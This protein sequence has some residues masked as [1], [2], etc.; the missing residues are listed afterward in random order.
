MENKFSFAAVGMFV[1]GFGIVLLSLIVWLTVGTEKVTYLPYKV[2]T[3][4]S[5]SGLSV[6][7]I[8][9]YKGVN[10]GVVKK[11]QLNDI[12][13][14]YV[15]ISLDIIKG[16]PVKVDTEAVLTSRGITGLVT[17]SLRDGTESSPLMLPTETDPVPEIKNGPSLAK[18]L[19]TAFNEITKSI[20]G[21]S[22]K[23]DLV[24]TEKNA[25]HINSILGNMDV[26]SA[27][28][29]KSSTDIHTITSD[30]AVLLTN[31][32]PKID[33]ALNAVDSF[34]S[35]TENLK[36]ASD[37][38]THTLKGADNTLSAWT[39][40]AMEWQNMGKSIR[41]Q[42]PNL[43]STFTELNNVLYQ[44]SLLMT[45]LNNQPDSLIMGKSSAKPGPGE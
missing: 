29:A 32:E 17:I 42:I 34:S 30:A 43:N 26:V 38:L 39:S 28:L 12:D 7:S 40:T 27:N 16:T 24:L 10:V 44:M 35:I 18:R 19:D 33:R 36:A 9:D 23:L 41:T 1:V 4:E 6:N 31:L 2:V 20:S 14:R 45:Q 13:P 37:G 11:I 5:V 22:E 8:V 25:E 15:I 3:N 21:L